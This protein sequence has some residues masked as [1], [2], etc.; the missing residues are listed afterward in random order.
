MI[1][2]GGYGNPWLIRDIRSLLSGQEIAA[3]TTAEKR[4][5]ALQHL[6]WHREQFG[7]RKTLYEMRKHLCWYARG[8]NGASLF[9]ATLQQVT[10]IDAL[11]EQIEIFF[12]E[13]RNE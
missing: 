1:G 6:Q 8:L 7:E 10:N 5:V 12:D 9:R 2:R 4:R 3:V 11:V 13:G